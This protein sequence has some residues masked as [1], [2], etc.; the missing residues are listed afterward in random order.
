MSSQDLQNRKSYAGEGETLGAKI[1]PS[2]PLMAE[3]LGRNT[4]I[5]CGQAVLE[6]GIAAITSS[7]LMSQCTLN[8]YDD[9]D[10]DVII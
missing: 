7:G 6:I 9:D 3:L 5:V 10:N 2:A 8:T 4:S 1:W